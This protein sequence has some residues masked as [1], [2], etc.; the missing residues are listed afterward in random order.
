MSS[1]YS[2]MK[3]AR[4]EGKQG[5][6]K[7]KRICLKI[8]RNNLVAAKDRLHDSSD[9]DD[10]LHDSSDEDH[11]LP[12]RIVKK[13]HRRLETKV[14][15]VHSQLQKLLSPDHS[16]LYELT[17]KLG[18]GTFGT[19]WKAQDKEL[20]DTVA[21]KQITMGQPEY[22]CAEI[23]NLSKCY[24]PNIPAH[25]ES[26]Q[27]HHEVWLVMEYIQGMDV[28]ELM[29]HTDLTVEEVASVCHGTLSALKY[30]H[31]RDI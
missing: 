17:E 31:S 18:S 14:D 4:V 28:A 19:V 16:H 24:H 27:V 3:R 11:F 7:P 9:E 29:G 23:S 26:F 6:M 12:N 5:G 21:V 2:P 20:G 8:D 22:L 30:L 13:A 10:F 15:V 1:M 25:Y